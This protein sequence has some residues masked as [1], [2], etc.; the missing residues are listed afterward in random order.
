MTH[1]MQ[2]PRDSSSA[3]LYAFNLAALG[4]THFAARGVGPY[5][6][7]GRERKNCNRIQMFPVKCARFAAPRLNLTV[8]LI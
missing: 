2:P 1:L 8:S 7:R 5:V 6:A 3:G 4:Q